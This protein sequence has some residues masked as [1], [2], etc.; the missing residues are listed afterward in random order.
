[1][2]SAQMARRG[3]PFVSARPAVLRGFRLDFTYPAFERWLGGAADIVPEPAGSVEGVLYGLADE[4][5][6][7]KMDRWEGVHER[8]Y[9]RDLVEVVLPGMRDP[10]P[11]WA[12]A[13]V[14]KRT[15]MTPSPGYIG[16]MVVGA[17]ANGLSRG[18]LG[19]LEGILGRSRREMRPL[20][21]VLGALDARKGPVAVDEVAASAHI[22]REQALAHL[23]DLSG[24]GWAEPTPDGGY[25]LRPDRWA[26]VPKVTGSALAL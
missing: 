5:D 6:L 25:R 23:S 1:M 24:W 8:A 12:Y 21:R 16:Q 26:D 14:D 18:Y 9:R 13:V 22:S 10:V 2:D 20:L 11:A 3:V 15:P 19:M 7:P 17:R 4:S